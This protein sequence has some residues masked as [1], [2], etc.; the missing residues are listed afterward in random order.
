MCYLFHHLLKE[1]FWFILTFTM[2]MLKC[3]MWEILTA[4]MRI[5]KNILGPQETHEELVRNNPSKAIKNT[6]P[7]DEKRWWK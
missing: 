2:H 5:Q 6:R 4:P 3:I 7:E 1:V